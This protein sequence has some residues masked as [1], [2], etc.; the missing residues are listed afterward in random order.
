MSLLY[1]VFGAVFG[2]VVCFLYLA[3]FD[4]KNL[5]GNLRRCG[6]VKERSGTSN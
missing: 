1:S 2:T 4:R 6:A 3:I 5:F